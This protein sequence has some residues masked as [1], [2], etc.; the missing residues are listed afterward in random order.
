MFALDERPSKGDAHPP[1]VV[2]D[3]LSALPPLLFSL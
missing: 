1:R 3:A 2:R